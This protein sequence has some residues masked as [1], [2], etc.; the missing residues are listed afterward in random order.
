[1]FHLRS[2]YVP[3]MLGFGRHQCFVVRFCEEEDNFGDADGRT[4]F[5]RQ[6]RLKVV[7]LCAVAVNRVRMQFDEGHDTI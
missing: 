7:R 4:G 5:G 1:M 6:V 2:Q 3:V